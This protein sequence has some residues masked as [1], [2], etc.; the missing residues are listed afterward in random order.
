MWLAES[1]LSDLTLELIPKKNIFGITVTYISAT[2]IE[3]VSILDKASINY[4][5]NN[6]PS[7]EYRPFLY[8]IE[9]LNVPVLNYESRIKDSYKFKE[10]ILLDYSHRVMSQVIKEPIEYVLQ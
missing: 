10:R 5:K 1:E 4:L 7:L 9:K 8:K 2:D 6:I 3:N